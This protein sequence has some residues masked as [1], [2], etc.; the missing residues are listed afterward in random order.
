M[1]WP[2]SEGAMVVWQRLCGIHDGKVSL[3]EANMCP[4][5][6]FRKICESL[7]VWKI[8]IVCVAE[9]PVQINYVH[10]AK[11]GLGHSARQESASF[12]LLNASPED[13]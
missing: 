8:H 9:M 10:P 3:S 2:S 7:H 4:E 11:D 13:P 12:C 1:S 6:I 5:G